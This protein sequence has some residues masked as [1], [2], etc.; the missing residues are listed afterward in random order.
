[1][2]VFVDGETGERRFQ[3]A[4]W[5][6]DADPYPLELERLDSA[7]CLL[8]DGMFLR[9]AVEAA[10]HARKRGIPVVADLGGVEGRQRELVSLVDYLVT[11]ED[12]AR[13]V[14]G[15]DDPERACG[16]MLEMGPRAV[17]V[18]LGERGSVYS[19]GRQ[20]RRQ[21]AFPVS[22]VDTTGAGDCFHGAFSVGVVRGWAL[23][24]TVRFAS[25]AAAIKCQQLGGR[26][27]LP[28]MTEVEAFLKERGA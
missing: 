3:L 15:G 27:G 22:V 19:D 7:K 1:V 9:A 24:E 8:V 16:L 2:L 20:A 12:C 11:N 23:A 18:T 14:A 5:L 6:Q 28:R 4:R 17:V 25:A 10:Q 13:R 21:P 26:A